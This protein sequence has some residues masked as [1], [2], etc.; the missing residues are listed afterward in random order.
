MRMLRQAHACVRGKRAM[1]LRKFT[2]HVEVQ[3][4]WVYT[5]ILYSLSLLVV[6]GLTCEWGRWYSENSHQ[7]VQTR[8]LMEGKLSIGKSPAELQ[9]D[10]AW[11][12]DGVQQVWGLGISLWRLPFYVLAKACGFEAFPDMLAFGAALGLA[13]WL[14]LRFIFCDSGGVL[15]RGGPAVIG[16]T[17]AASGPGIG[18]MEAG[19][20]LKLLGL[21]LGATGL[22]LCFPPFLNLLRSRF[23]IYEEVIAYEYVAGLMLVACLMN[24]AQR[25]SNRTYWCLCAFAGIGG[26]FRPTLVF[27]GA[28]AVLAGSVA[29]GMGGGM[30]VAVRGEKQ[31]PW[32]RS[33]RRRSLAVG[34]GLFA[35]GG[36]VLFVTNLIRFGDGFEFGH[37]LNV[38]HFYGSLYA[39]RF[40]DPYQ[41]ESLI[42]SGRE[43]FGLLFLAKDLNGFDFYRASFFPGQSATVRWREIYLTAYDCSYFVWLV[44][45]FATGV[46][47]WRKLWRW[48]ASNEQPSWDER[49]R[50]VLV[51]EL[52]LFGTVG[53]ALLLG[54]YLRCP[55]IS[56]RYLLDLMPSFVALMLAAWM[57]WG[58]FWAKHKGGRWVMPASI[59]VLAGW[60][61][62]QNSESRSCYGSPSVLTWAEIKTQQ[63]QRAALTNPPL[64]G[65]YGSPAAP[66][67]TA[68]PYNGA[69]W[70]TWSGMVMPCVI[71][72]VEHP[73]FL[74][75]EVAAEFKADFV[76]NPE[77]FRAKVGLEFLKRESIKAT[78]KGWII[79][80]QGPK[81]RRYQTGLQPVF[82]ATVPNT[83][84]ADETTPWRLLK[85]RWKEPGQT[86]Q[87]PTSTVQ[88]RGSR[89]QTN[90][91]SAQGGK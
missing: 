16:V 85:V 66:V 81:R 35:L 56:S 25:P 2:K 58:G 89:A 39:T 13:A 73:A 47:A 76:P 23:D 50:V 5:A 45:G 48:C 84:L 38:Q 15:P 20:S 82:L 32:P 79:R 22:L 19:R 43:L 26:L 78:E 71:L 59:V 62:C 14:M 1:L 53:S 44:A 6:C 74:E 90:G 83:H 8:A 49:L 17:N 41:A 30:G 72:F 34:A 40:D 42:A 60:L 18:G 9:H 54:F 75:L 68:I 3:W 67:A 37:R 28:A 55:V 33:P 63:H 12:E 64:S 51:G 27:H 4:V 70:D 88:S 21:G 57:A 29:F 31:M 52:A 91:A 24:L 69:G 80:F 61:W 46:A 11:A 87:S 7:R 10:L 77:Q 65:V 86:V 36:S